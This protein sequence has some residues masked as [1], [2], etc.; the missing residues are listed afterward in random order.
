MIRLRS[1]RRVTNSTCSTSKLPQQTHQQHQDLE[2]QHHHI[3]PTTGTDKQAKM[4][5]R[6]IKRGVVQR[7]SDAGKY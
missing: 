5:K 4:G 7:T 6:E 2:S 1:N 3:P